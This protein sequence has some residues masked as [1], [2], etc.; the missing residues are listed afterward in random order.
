V[1]KIPPEHTA[2]KSLEN[3]FRVLGE[4]RARSRRGR[5]RSLASTRVVLATLTSV[6]VAG[7]VATGTKVFTSDGDA[8]HPDDPG[9]TGV[10][11]RVDPAPDGRRLALARAPDPTDPQRW[12]LRMYKSA[13]GFTCL[14]LGRVVDGRLGVIRGGQ[15]K[16][17]PARSGGMCAALDTE[18]VVMAVRMYADGGDSR[19]RTVVYGAVDRTVRAVRVVSIHGRATPV[20]I[21][22]DGTFIVVR[23]GDEPFHLTRLV[24]D[25]SGGRQVRPLAP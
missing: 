6:L 24:I 18:H 22:A 25:G 5:R 11:G 10:R 23:G 13:S 21:A 2:A 19:R 3:A 16:E 7:G 8:L 14:T 17:L 9:L 20:P 4:E 1:T 15:F 12:G